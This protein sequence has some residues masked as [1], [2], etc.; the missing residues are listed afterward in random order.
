[1]APRSRLQDCQ[2]KFGGRSGSGLYIGWSLGTRLGIRHR[3][4]LVKDAS[5]LMRTLAT[6]VMALNSPESGCNV[7][8]AGCKRGLAA[9]WNSARSVA[10]SC[11]VGSRDSTSRAPYLMRASTL[12]CLAIMRW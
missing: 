4:Y 7:V 11:S 3:D 8:A 9:S 5:R 2:L 6:A 1:M 10:N 12:G